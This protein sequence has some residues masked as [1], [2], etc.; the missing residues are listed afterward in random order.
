ME[1]KEIAERIKNIYDPGRTVI[2]G[3][4]GLGGAGKSTVSESLYNTN[5]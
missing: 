4:D 5:S 1:L 2:V 3:I